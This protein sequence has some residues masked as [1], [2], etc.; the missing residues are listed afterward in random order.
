M[1]L[2]KYLISKCCIFNFY[3][4]RFFNTRLEIFSVLV[5]EKARIGKF[6]HHVQ[7]NISFPTPRR[8]IYVISDVVS[9]KI[10]YFRRGVG[11]FFYLPF[12]IPGRKIFLTVHRLKKFIKI[13]KRKPT[14]AKFSS[15]FLDSF[16]KCQSSIMFNNL[17]DK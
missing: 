13:H 15:E 9:E 3:G 2:R 16:F 12:L 8:K 14:R 6:L 4:Q 5:S 11:I 17:H 10:Y 1:F 7:N